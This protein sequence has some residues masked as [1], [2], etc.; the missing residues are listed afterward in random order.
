MHFLKNPLFTLPTSK[1]VIP[2][3]PQVVSTVVVH[4]VNGNSDQHFS[5]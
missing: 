3:F 1:K 5:T 2:L 4:T